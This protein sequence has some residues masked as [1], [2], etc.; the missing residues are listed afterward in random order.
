MIKKIFSHITE[1]I[2]DLKRYEA[3]NFAYNTMAAIR[4]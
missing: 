4:R 3:N 2:C 1:G